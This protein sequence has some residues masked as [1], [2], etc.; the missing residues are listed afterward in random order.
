MDPAPDETASSAEGRISQTPT[1]GRAPT[2]PSASSAGSSSPRSGVRR[3]RRRPVGPATL[4]SFVIL[5]LVVGMLLTGFAWILFATGLVGGEAQPTGEP[6]RAGGE[7]GTRA[8]RIVDPRRALDPATPLVRMETIGPTDWQTTD[9]PYAEREPQGQIEL[10]DERIIAVE[11]GAAEGESRFM[12]AAKVVN[13]GIDTV[14]VAALTLSLVDQTP[15]VYAT[16]VTLV[17]MID[18]DSPREVRVEIPRE[19][20][21]QI[22]RVQWSAQVWKTLSS[23]VELPREDVALE[24]MGRGPLTMARVTA[25]NRTDRLLSRVIFVLLAENAQGHPVGVWRHNWSEAMAPGDVIE[26]ASP[27]PV[28]VKWGSLNWSIE[29]TGVPIQDP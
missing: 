19:L 14:E 2:P 24:T 9:E 4:L 28:D 11:N 25:A 1:A 15:R 27:V 8:D 23:A 10:I 26:F 13:Q 12:Y 20:A 3:R 18:H 6:A 21:E 16:G 17:V 7:G 29:A 22:D 5:S